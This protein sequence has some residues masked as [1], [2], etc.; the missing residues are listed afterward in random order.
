MPETLLFE[1]TYFT[2]EGHPWIRDA[3]IR[4]AVPTC[5][6][7][8][9]DRI[10]EAQLKEALDVV[11]ARQARQSGLPQPAHWYLAAL[12]ETDP[13]KR[14]LWACFALE[15]LI[16]DASTTKHLP[17]YQQL[18]TQVKAMD[19]HHQQQGDSVPTRCSLAWFIRLQPRPLTW[20]EWK[21]LYDARS[22]LAH[23]AIA[24]PDRTPTAAVLRMLEHYLRL[25][26]GISTASMPI[27]WAR[28]DGS[29]WCA[30][31]L[32]RAGR[33]RYRPGYRE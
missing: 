17:N 15:R 19:P 4:A 24:S 9:P 33:R 5:T 23:G 32:G 3:A 31:R 2:A 11:A 29:A 20:A 22:D 18:I 21:T 7:L 1:R 26:I 16:N 25:V 12:A 14:F 13:W 8:S 28:R 27:A 6:P 30:R 10:G